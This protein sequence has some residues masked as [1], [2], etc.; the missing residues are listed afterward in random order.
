MYIW[1]SIWYYFSSVQRASFSIYLNADLLVTN[2]LSFCFSKDVLILPLSLKNIFVRYKILGWWTIFFLFWY[3][4]HPIISRM[5]LSRFSPVWLFATPWSVTHQT[6]LSKGLSRQEYWSGLWC[7][8]P[9]DLPYP[10]IKPVSLTFSALSAASLPQ[11]PPG[12][13]PLSPGFH[14]LW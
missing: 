12:K 14:Y 1:F 11:A 9:G 2:F 4:D 8:P 10:A 13:F 7:P 5:L 6:P 3:L